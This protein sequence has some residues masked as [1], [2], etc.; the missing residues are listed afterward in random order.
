MHLSIDLLDDHFTM[1]PTPLPRQR[2]ANVTLREQRQLPKTNSGDRWYVCKVW[3]S[4][5]HLMSL[6]AHLSP[7]ILWQN[8]AWHT[9]RIIGGKN[10]ATLARKP[11]PVIAD[12]SLSDEAR[13]FFGFLP[14]CSGRQ[15][16]QWVWV[17]SRCSISPWILGF[18]DIIGHWLNSVTTAVQRTPQSNG[19]SSIK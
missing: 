14:L 19:D 2:T 3:F 4:F 15:Q 1:R 11:L 8:A 7:P 9:C 13:P 16:F 10:N 18:N 17:Y 12:K 5:G 6:H